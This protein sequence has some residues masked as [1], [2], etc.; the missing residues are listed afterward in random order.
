MEFVFDV[1]EDIITQLIACL[2][3]AK[4][5][6]KKEVPE[7]QFASFKDDPQNLTLVFSHTSDCIVFPL[8][9]P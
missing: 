4:K 9:P 1:R 5:K 8:S 2:V 6:K 7:S 3:L